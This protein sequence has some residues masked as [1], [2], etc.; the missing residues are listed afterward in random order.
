M[1][2]E[3]ISVGTEILMG[4]ITNT[5]ARYIADKLREL[6]I[7]VYYQTTV[8]DN[9]QRLKEVIKQALNRSDIVITTG[10]LGPT[11]D[12][13]TVNVIARTLDSPLVL[14][15]DWLEYLREVTAKFGVKL[16]E[17]NIKQAY[18]PEGAI[19]MSNSRGTA[20]GVY[21]EKDEKIVVALP[22]P[23]IEMQYVFD[24]ELYQRLAVKSKEHLCSHV[25]KTIGIGEAP[26]ENEIRELIEK[27]TDPTVAL[28]AK[29]GEVHIRLATKAVSDE[30][31]WGRIKPIKDEITTRIGRYIFGSDHDTIE[32]VVGDL[33]RQKGLKLACAESCTG[34]LLGNRITSM[35]G[36]SAYFLGGIVSYANSVKENVLGVSRQSLEQYGAVSEQVAVEMAEGA[37]KVTGADVAVAITGIAGPGGGTEDKPVGT[38]HLAIVGKG[39]ETIRRHRILIGGRQEVKY[40]STQLALYDLW[41]SLKGLEGQ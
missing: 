25:I 18:M 40:R 13:I 6:G 20:P 2:A 41:R 7:D 38:V 35:A 32:G 15:E 37:I 24:N 10:G 28:Y 34:G 33:L 22:G 1:K 36:S 21:I 27:Q 17:N 11:E 31:A 39:I 8:G 14:Y 30:E 12:D 9:H 19:P 26:L 16:T 29:S 23:P 3:I 4:E 5:N